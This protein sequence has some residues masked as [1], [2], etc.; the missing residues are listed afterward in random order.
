VFG[1]LLLEEEG[2]FGAFYIPFFIFIMSFFFMNIMLGFLVD[3]LTQNDTNEPIKTRH[4]NEIQEDISEKIID[5]LIVIFFLL[6]GFEIH[7]NVNSNENKGKWAILYE[8]TMDF[9]YICFFF[10]W[11]F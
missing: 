6:S 4:S 10:L 7:S 9:F 8:F 2:L 1:R 11:V 5:V 3:E